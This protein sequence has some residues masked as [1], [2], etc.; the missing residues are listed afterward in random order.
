MIFTRE[1]RTSSV[2]N[3]QSP[4]SI[5]HHVPS[6]HRSGCHHISRTRG[7]IV[8]VLHISSDTFMN[9]PIKIAQFKRSLSE[10]QAHWADWKWVTGD[11]WHTSLPGLHVL[12]NQVSPT[13]GLITGITQNNDLITLPR[14]LMGCHWTANN[15]F[16]FS[17][18][19]FILELELFCKCASHYLRV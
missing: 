13:D 10:F 18:C 8:T 19:F 3:G 6:K 5:C 4:N 17:I 16:L 14:S 12:N 1:M 9:L 15:H 11:C 7:E 2:A